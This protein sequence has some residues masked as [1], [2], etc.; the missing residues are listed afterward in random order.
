[1]AGWMDTSIRF[2]N[3]STVK[4]ADNGWDAI[5]FQ[6]GHYSTYEVVNCKNV[7]MT[8]NRGWVTN[9]GDLIFTD[10]IIDISDNAQTTD[11]SYNYGNVGASCSNLYAYSLTGTGGS[12]YGREIPAAAGGLREGRHSSGAGWG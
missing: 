4:M 10:S 5:N 6:A 1:M 7:D 2:E 3:I 12:Q 11:S 9:G 8:G